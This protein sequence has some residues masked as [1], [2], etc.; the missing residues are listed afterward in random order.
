MKEIKD[1][2]RK[3]R[4]YLHSRSPDDWNTFTAQRN[5]VTT[6]LRRAKS[7]FVN[8][9][10]ASSTSLHRLM[11]HLTTATKQRIPELVSQATP[12]MT[13]AQKAAA[14]NEFFISQS[15]LSVDN[16][17]EQTPAIN[18]TPDILSPFKKSRLPRLRSKNSSAELIPIKA[19][20]STL[21]QAAYSKKRL[22]NLHRRYHP[23]LIYRSKPEKSH[24]T[25]KMP[26]LLQY[27]SPV[28]QHNQQITD[29][30]LS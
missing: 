26:P 6:L 29:P 15:K 7:D 8:N 19:P 27:R 17:D 11:K 9:S 28:T 16:A 24:R 13:P 1:K 20:G 25:G 23:S 4:I 3:H 22:R 12:A 2:H 10:T 18:T 21:F 5:R 30:S 14:L